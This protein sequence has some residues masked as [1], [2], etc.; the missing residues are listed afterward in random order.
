MSLNTNYDN[1]TLVANINKFMP[2]NRLE[3]VED[4]KQEERDFLLLRWRPL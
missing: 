1:I 2:H 3:Y 4:R